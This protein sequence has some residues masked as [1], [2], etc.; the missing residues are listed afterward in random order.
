MA[1]G[2]YENHCLG[3][4]KSIQNSSEDVLLR[5]YTAVM[6]GGQHSLY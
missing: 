5:K 3:L 2:G 6:M 1:E 4:C